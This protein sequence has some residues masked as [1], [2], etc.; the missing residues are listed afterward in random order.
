MYPEFAYSTQMQLILAITTFIS[1]FV[2]V[3][4]IADLFMGV[5]DTGTSKKQKM[6]FAFITGTLLQ[7]VLVYVVYFVGGGQPFSELSYL[8]ITIP[9][10]LFALLYYFIGV[11][12]LNIPKL[13]SFKM[14]S[15][16][17][18]FYL[19]IRGFYSLVSVM[20]FRQT[21]ANY[22]YLLDICQHCVCMVII[23]LLFPLSKKLSE[24]LKAPLIV[25]DKLF[26][27]YRS[28]IVL[29]FVRTCWGWLSYMIVPHIIT[30]DMP[31][32][33]TNIG[34]T[35]TILLLNILI[36]YVRALEVTLDNSQ[37]HIY[38][39]SNGLNNFNSLKH[40]FY[41]ILQTYNGYLE[42]GD[43]EKLKVY[44]SSLVHTTTNAGTSSDLGKRLNENPALIAL[45]TGKLEY[46]QENNV[47]LR[48]SLQTDIRD[49]YINNMDFCRALACLLDNAIEAAA[50]SNRKTVLFSAEDKA[51]FN[52]LI[53]ISNS[54]ATPIDMN[55]VFGMS[56]KKGHSGL[57]LTNVR[58]VLDKYG[59]CMFDLSSYDDEFT[60]YLDFQ[61]I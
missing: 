56:S 48:I 26:I 38:T 57:G 25:E 46:A 60:A 30:H 29:Y 7:S 13:R 61:K 12:V 17:Y 55:R 5:Y 4:L 53:I 51:C 6:L 45:L 31:A 15:N 18:L 39:L 42:L 22:N 20:F 23:L 9:N 14:M 32:N 21:E 19:V 44:H 34:I 24:K 54:T 43:L 40:D 50:E 10:P 28:E 1:T 35:L 33:I 58:K 49:F 47:V 37:A 52:K 27:S 2:V 3:Y 8:L 36:D 16:F 11:K 59:N 41:N